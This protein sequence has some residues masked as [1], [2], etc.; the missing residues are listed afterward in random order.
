VYIPSI[1][2]IYGVLLFVRLAWIVGNAGIGQA[3][4]ICSLATLCT[5]L[6]VL[7]MSAI[8]T[9]GKVA[10]GGAYYMISR[11]LGR[12]FGGS[13]GL[14]FCLANSVGCSMYVLGVVE[15]LVVKI[16]IRA[17]LTFESNY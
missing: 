15:I 12:E 2:N 4:L 1:S 3:L 16:Y 13:V 9:N 11:S 14:L 5:F 8:A 6:T 17:L 7:S 10:A